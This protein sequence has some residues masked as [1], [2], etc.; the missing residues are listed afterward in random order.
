M[1][2]DVDMSPPANDVSSP[3]IRVWRPKKKKK[4]KK[5]KLGSH[6]YLNSIQDIVLFTGNI[7]L[8]LIFFCLVR[9]PITGGDHGLALKL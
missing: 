3:S 6:F 1:Q 4:K 9:E 5:K 7:R 2:L 8:Q